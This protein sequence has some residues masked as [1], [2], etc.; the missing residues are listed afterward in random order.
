MKVLFEHANLSVRD[1]DGMILFLRTAFPEFKIRRDATDN[2]GKR[3]VHIGTNK[4]YI[5]LDK[6]HAEP[7]QKWTP[8]EGL[9]GVNHL[10]FEVDNV[11]ARR[12][13]ND[14]SKVA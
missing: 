13:L 8:Y 2:D 1:I 5:A 14:I 4:T 12:N 11:E 6:A 9:P 10:G 3:W 7:L